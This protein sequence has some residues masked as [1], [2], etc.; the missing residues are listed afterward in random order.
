MSCLENIITI[1]NTAITNQI[2]IN[3]FQSETVI[4]C[5]AERGFKI[6]M[7]QSHIIHTHN[8]T[9]EFS[10]KAQSKIQKIATSIKAVGFDIQAI[11]KNIHETIRYFIDSLSIIHFHLCSA[12]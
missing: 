4:N 12:I 3:H 8:Q 5:A 11:E 10:H 2:I 9:N 6:H 1:Q 7:N